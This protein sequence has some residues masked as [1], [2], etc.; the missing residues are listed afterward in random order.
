MHLHG[1]QAVLAFF[2]VGTKNRFV[3][4]CLVKPYVP[5]SSGYKNWNVTLCVPA[6]CFVV[7]ASS[8]SE[9]F[10]CL[11]VRNQVNQ[12]RLHQ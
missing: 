5:A 9:V 11:L 6:S 7:N 1:K 4:S 2:V 10:L 8:E 3:S 12:R